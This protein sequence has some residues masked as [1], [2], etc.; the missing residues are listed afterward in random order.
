VSEHRSRDL[1]RAFSSRV[2][3]RLSAVRPLAGPLTLFGCLAVAMWVAIALALRA[4]ERDAVVRA[5]I[6]GG[7]LAR[8]LAQHE[9]A[10]VQVLD[11]S[12]QYMRDEWL[13]DRESFAAAI[14]RHRR[15]LKDKSVLQVLIFGADGR[16]VWGSESGWKPVDVSD[17]PYFKVHRDAN[18]ADAL[19]IS[20]PVEGRVRTEVWT[21]RFTRPIY[22]AKNKF[23]GVIVFSVPPPALEKVYADIQLGAGGLISLL[24]TDGG[25]VARSSNLGAVV[26]RVLSSRDTI[27][28]R[29]QDPPYGIYRRMS[30]IGSRDSLFAYAKVSGYPL[31]VYVRQTAETVLA[32]VR[33][34]R[35][36]YVLAGAVATIVLVMFGWTL[37]LARREKK[38]ADMSVARL[39]AI[40]RDSDDGIAGLGL[41][42]CIESWNAGASRILG[43]S[44]AEMLGRNG[45]DLIVPPERLD[46]L[47]RAHALLHRGEY[48]PPFDTVR[49]DKSGRIV[50]AAV[51]MSPVKD[52]HG[53]VCGVSVIMHD[54]TERKQA[55]AARR[56]LEAQL[57]ESHKMEAIS[58]LAGGVAHDINNALGAILGNVGLAR[59]DA[60]AGRGERALVSIEEIARAGLRMK[61]LVQQMLTFSRKSQ[62]KMAPLNLVT[63]CEEQIKKIRVL[64]PPQVH[65]DFRPADRPLP[66]NGDATQIGNVLVILCDNA[67]RA[68]PEE[69]GRIAVVLTLL[70]IDA[71]AARR[72][73][74]LAEGDYACLGVSDNG[75]GMDE[76]LQLRIFE[77]FFTTRAVD[78]GNGLGLAVAHGIVKAH[79][80][81]IRVSSTPGGQHL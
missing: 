48:V 15:I 21:V 35:I 46:E 43:Y 74:Q 6:A 33:M 38:I 14:A 3:L 53:A 24:R 62:F 55:E 32:P 47:A 44:E 20:T 13:R 2:R 58:T 22:D 69:G 76:N 36:I 60:A 77:P 7:N 65:L 27:G 81:A 50:D 16:T 18:G 56:E 29:P 25:F 67:R 66:A 34:Q 64:L 42:G 63:L 61:T 78:E 10:R 5:D 28:L 40:V 59:R 9:A 4:A 71:A 57:R 12:L 39:A 70:H 72:D 1:V 68:L 17:R 19:D 11:H 30:A 54:I 45:R 80:G 51:S 8:S 41:D 73:G 37:G 52:E 23:A 75:C 79:R 31:T 26:G 49:I